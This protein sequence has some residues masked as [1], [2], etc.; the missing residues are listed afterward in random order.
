MAAAR[1]LLA[2]FDEVLGGLAS[3]WDDEAGLI[4]ITSDHGNLEDLSTRGHTANP[5]PGLVIGA[6]GLRRRFMSEWR[7]LTHIAPSIVE[8]LS[9]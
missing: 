6:P 5:V 9:K 2:T 7:D 3:A 8:A 1:T 4:L